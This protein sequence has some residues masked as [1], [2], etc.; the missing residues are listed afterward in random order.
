[1]FSLALHIGRSHPPQSSGSTV[2][3]L[4]WLH[5]VVHAGVLFMMVDCKLLQVCK[6]SRCVRKP[7]LPAAIS[8]RLQFGVNRSMAESDFHVS[9]PS[10]QRETERDV[11][12][13]QEPAYSK[14][15]GRKQQPSDQ[16]KPSSAG[17][18]MRVDAP[19]FEWPQP[20]HRV[21][22]D[23]C[24]PSAASAHNMIERTNKL[25]QS[26]LVCLSCFCWVTSLDL[27]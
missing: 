8:T 18:L 7:L 11:Q 12:L 17:S 16:Q 20:W 23:E 1:M 9:R 10:E 24:L 25:W 3:T 15:W 27:T 6:S 19:D 26:E 13:E 4:P 2:S 22:T 5:S 14:K 21:W